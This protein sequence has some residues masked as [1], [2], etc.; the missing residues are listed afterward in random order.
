MNVL[1]KVIS[2]LE[3]SSGKTEIISDLRSSGT[4]MASSSVMTQLGVGLSLVIVL[5]SLYVSHA[6]GATL[7]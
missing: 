3:M 1:I 5:K 2:Q 7:T 4:E 6:E